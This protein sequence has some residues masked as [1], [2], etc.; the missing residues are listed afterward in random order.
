MVRP[1]AQDEAINYAQM[2]EWTSK[3]TKTNQVGQILIE[4]MFPS[5]AIILQAYATSIKDKTLPIKRLQETAGMAATIG[6]L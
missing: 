3:H 5:Q 1:R 4:V 2:R 6:V